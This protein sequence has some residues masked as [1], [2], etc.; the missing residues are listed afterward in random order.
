MK[1]HSERITKLTPREWAISIILHL[2]VFGLLIWFTPARQVLESLGEKN[3]PAEAKPPR[4]DPTQVKEVVKAISQEQADAAKEHVK[5]LL[6]EEK[7]LDQLAKDRLDDYKRQADSIAADAAQKAL[8][9]LKQ[10][11]PGQDATLQAQQQLRQQLQANFPN[12]PPPPPDQNAMRQKRDQLAA[13]QL[14]VNHAYLYRKVKFGFVRIRR[15]AIG[16]VSRRK[17]RC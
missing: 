9:L 10:I 15:S 2:V 12:T 16:R 1:T 5:Q 4:Q 6:D 11:P 14:T 8:D 13:S 17:A 7:K 3:P